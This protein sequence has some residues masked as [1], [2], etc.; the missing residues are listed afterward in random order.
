MPNTQTISSRTM[1]QQADDF[2]Q[3]MP[4]GLQ[5]RQTDAIVAAING[6]NTALMAVRN[7]RNTPPQPDKS[8]ATRMLT[9]TLRLYE[10]VNSNQ[11]PLPVLVYLHGG[12]WTFGSLNSC[13]RFCNAMAATGRLKVVA[14]DYR[15]AP[16]YP[17]PEGLD[18]CVAAVEFVKAHAKEWG[19]DTARIVVGGDSSGGNLALATALT[20]RLRGCVESLV[21]FY[22]V[23]KAFADGSDSWRKFGKGYGLDADIMEAFNRAYTLT[24]DPRHPAVSIALVPDESLS[25]LP[26]TLIVSA[27]RDILCDQGRELAKRM[28]SKATR[29]VFA[30]AVHL[31]ITVPG[32]DE[33]FV[34][35][36]RCAADFIAPGKMKPGRVKVF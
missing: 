6:D 23:T 12:G 18:D 7:A 35:A 26:R 20:D 17:F 36:V 28:G 2:L 31:F 9:P 1:R 34:Q 25:A 4:A 3:A 16:E 10:P 22:P 29:I 27:G 19:I 5:Q 24:T 33:A 11:E 32:Q 21:L 8:V 30:D 15:L 13:G 14:V